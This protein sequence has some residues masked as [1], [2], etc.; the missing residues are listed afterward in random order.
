MGFIFTHNLTR[1]SKSST[2]FYRIKRKNLIAMLN[3]VKTKKPPIKLSRC[4]NIN[5]ASQKVLSQ[6][7]QSDE[8]QSPITKITPHRKARG[9]YKTVKE[10]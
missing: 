4:L 6:N 2:P 7:I 5:F 8:M 3:I 10:R 1:M 9:P